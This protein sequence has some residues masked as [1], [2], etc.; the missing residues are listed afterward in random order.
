[1]HDLVSIIGYS[2]FVGLF[3]FCVIV[4]LDKLYHLIVAIRELS[5]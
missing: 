1:M 4:A 5:I 3:A 2:Y